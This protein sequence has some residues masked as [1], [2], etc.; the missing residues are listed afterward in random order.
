MTDADGTCTYWA[1]EECEG[2]AHCPPR[3]PRFV[4]AAGEAWVV[5]PATAADRAA[6]VEMYDDFAPGEQAQGLPPRHRP[7]LEEWVDDC[8]EDGCN[9]VVTGEDGPV[10]HALYTPTDAAEPEF[11]VF[12]H[13]D[14]Q[15]RGIGTEV[16]KHVL[17]AAAVADRDA[18]TLVVE[19]TNRAARHVY[20][21]L[22]FETESEA[23]F[24]GGR[25]M[26]AVRMRRPL[27]AGSTA[28]FRHPPVV[29]NGAVEV[30]D[31]SG[32]DPAASD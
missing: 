25:R 26:G 21:E 24:E 4:D 1:P 17:A 5:R 8:L 23:S 15:G 10:G 2:T 22:G 18:L 12:V 16:S 19:P 3:C 14:Y 6:L 32:P 27:D 9:F 30:G 29:R 31:R 11:A 13:Q 28:L 20:D 7:R